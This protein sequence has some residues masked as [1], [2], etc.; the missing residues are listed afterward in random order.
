MPR[1]AEQLSPIKF[2]NHLVTITV[3]NK[4]SMPQ[5]VPSPASRKLILANL[6]EAS[7]CACRS[8]SVKASSD[9]PTDFKPARCIFQ[10]SPTTRENKLKPGGAH[11][12]FGKTVDN[13]IQ[14]SPLS[15][16]ESIGSPLTSPTST[17]SPSSVS[18]LSHFSP[19]M[20]ASQA[21]TSLSNNTPGDLYS[22]DHSRTPD[23]SSSTTLAPG[24]ASLKDLTSEMSDPWAVARQRSA[25]D[26]NL[27]SD[28][29]VFVISRFQC[30]CLI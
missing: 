8:C 30:V 10:Q 17:V 18:T 26:G 20:Q 2:S 21:R 25:S 12:A 6:M 4:C 19:P 7:S 11:F 1:I 27:L 22:A 24:S 13:S 3:D 15:D 23:S 16:V 5:P 14:K 29:K 9:E 28:S